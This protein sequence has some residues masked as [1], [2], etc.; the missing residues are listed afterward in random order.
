MK[1]ETKN[2]EHKTDP[3][4][5][6]FTYQ[7]KKYTGLAQPIKASCNDDVCFEMEIILNREFRGTI[8]CGS[9]LKWSGKGAVDQQLIDKI[10]EEI[11]LW[12]E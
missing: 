4:P 6:S 3:I 8:S 2:K 9:N 7:G 1:M 10:G 12:Y 11:V 5:L